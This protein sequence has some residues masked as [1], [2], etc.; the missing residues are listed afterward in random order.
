[1]TTHAQY[2]DLENRLFG[3]LDERIYAA[4]PGDG[5]GRLSRYRRDSL[6]DPRR[7]QPDWNRSFEL[8]PATPRAA[9]L[10]LHGMS[11]SPYSLRAIGERLNATGVH[12]LGLRLPGHGT[13]PSGLLTVSWEDLAAATRLGVRHLSEANPG[14]P[15][16]AIG[17]STGAA[18]AVSYALEALTDDAEPRL[19][20]LTLLSPAI[21]VS[22]AAALAVWQARLGYLLGLEKLAWNVVAPE[23]DPYKYGSFA[24]NAGD[25]VYRGTL[26]IQQ[27]L[28]ALAGSRALEELAPVVAYSS[29]VDATVSAPAL[30]TGLLDRLPANGH[31]LV[32]FDINRRAE[33]DFILRGNPTAVIESLLRGRDRPFSLSVLSNVSPDVAAVEVRR[34]EPGSSEPRVLPLEAAWPAGTFALAHVSLPFPPDDPIYGIAAPAKGSQDTVRLGNLALRGERGVLQVSAED[35]LRLRCN[36]F[37]PFVEEGILRQ[38]GLLAP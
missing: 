38:L 32:L 19:D 18:L 17:Y 22:P 2:L 27:Q 3:A 11:D 10:L 14:V 4:Q 25:V 28:D 23:Y 33:L 31:E 34:W 30:L 26:R 9:V 5:S 21:G 36:P 8:R 7:L 35:Q 1:V 37:Y 29:V 12:V 13:A 6:A 20:G 24:V 16:Y 15:L